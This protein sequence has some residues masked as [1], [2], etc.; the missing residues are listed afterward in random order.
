M[1]FNGNTTADVLQIDASDDE[2]IFSGAITKPPKTITASGLAS[3]DDYHVLLDASS[4]ALDYELPDAT[5]ANL[6]RT[7]VVT[8][9]NNTN[10]NEFSVGGASSDT[11]QFKGSTSANRT[12]TSVGETYTLRVIQ[13]NV[14][15]VVTVN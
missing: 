1:S 11:I 12:A 8:F 3:L 9:I 14:W 15:L 2:V 10:T 6:G 7:I 5:V 4:A 13:D